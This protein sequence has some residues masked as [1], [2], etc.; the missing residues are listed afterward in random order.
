MFKNLIALFSSLVFISAC[1]NGS[2]SNSSES[3]ASSETSGSNATTSTPAADFEPLEP[4]TVV[5]ITV[6]GDLANEPVI[7]ISSEASAVS[8]LVIADQLVGSGDSVVETSTV[9][10]HY[11]GV[12]LTTG[13]V[14]DSSWQRGAPIEFGLN[15]V[16]PGWT[17]GLTGMQIGGRRVLVIPADLA[18]GLTPPA[19]SGIEPNETLIFVV[20][21][22]DFR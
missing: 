17:Q 16:I 5:G 6:T 22:I 21:L 2:S 18:Y 15:Q 4:L 1:S 3:S 20:D 9:L 19:G 10:A 14:F 7:E 13:Q 8:E 12:G 11:I